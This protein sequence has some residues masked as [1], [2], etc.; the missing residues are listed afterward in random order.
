[1]RSNGFC[2]D[3]KLFLKSHDLDAFIVSCRHNIF[4]LSGFEGLSPYERE[5]FVLITK[6]K[7]YLI[8]DGR[9]AITTGVYPHI[10]KL[11]TNSDHPI[12]YYLRSISKELGIAKV[13]FEADDLTWQEQHIFSQLS[14]TLFPML[15]AF[16]AEREVKRDEELTAISKACKIGDSTLKE[17]IPLISIGK[18]EREIAW[19]LEQIIREKYKSEVAFDPIIAI[20]ENAAN[21]H[22]NTKKGEGVILKNSLVLIDFGVKWKNYCSDITRMVAVGKANSEIDSMYEVLKHTQNIT[23]K[24]IKKL[25]ALCKIDHFC[26]KILQEK[27][28]NSYPHSTGHGVGL[29]LHEWPKISATSIDDKKK[30]QVF[31]IEPGVYQKGKWGMRIEDTGYI[32]SSG[33][34]QDLTRFSRELIRL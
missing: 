20:N 9:Y 16:K 3:R 11:I 30:N 15:E 29:E 14:I 13:G 4:F 5:A 6:S 22:Y 8:T 24:K 25:R 32:T 31:T 28:L 26:R 10:K 21:P 23:K 7:T 27:G 12:S 18:T 33:E 1:M 19:K 17:I 34:F 2:F